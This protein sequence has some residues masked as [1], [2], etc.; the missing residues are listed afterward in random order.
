MSTNPA[1]GRTGEVISPSPSLF[2]TEAARALVDESKHTSPESRTDVQRLPADVSDNAGSGK[3][4]CD[5]EAWK[6]ATSGRNPSTSLSKVIKQE[7]QSV[8]GEQ[9]QVSDTGRQEQHDQQYILD[10]IYKHRRR[11][12]KTRYCV[13]WYVYSASNDIYEQP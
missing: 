2:H 6:G 7:L 4:R 12:W 9:Q 1:L 11:M 3:A 8:K 5:K 13:G 10:T